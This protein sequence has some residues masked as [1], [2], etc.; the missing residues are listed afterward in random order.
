MYFISGYPYTV[1]C[2]DA[3][4]K[5]WLHALQHWAVLALIN[6]DM[7][8]AEVVCSSA[9]ATHATGSWS[10]LAYTDDMYI[11]DILS[12]SDMYWHIVHS[13][14]IVNNPAANSSVQHCYWNTLFDMFLFPFSL[15]SI[16]CTSQRSIL[17]LPFT[18]SLNLLSW[19]FLK[20]V[21][22]S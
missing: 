19:I 7:A 14:F 9:A 8:V 17:V 20:T 22:S 21:S 12:K 5:Y 2:C 16:H 3:D 4:S 15:L 6:R 1:V 10:S 13:N 11:S 18:L